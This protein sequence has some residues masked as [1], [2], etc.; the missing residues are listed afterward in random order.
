MAGC[1][2]KIIVFL[3]N[4]IFMLC[5]LAVMIFGIIT[6]ASPSTVI[7]ALSFIPGYQNV[8][9]IIDVQQAVLN[10]GILMT[11]I[12]A[13]TFV[14]C[15]FGLIASCCSVTCLIGTYIF[16]VLI[17][18]YFEVAVII[19]FSVE[20]QYVNNRIENLMYTSLVQNFQPVSIVGN[21]IVNGSTSAAMAWEGIQ[22]KY[23]CCGAY[24]YLDFQN[25]TSWKQNFTYNP[26]A[27]VPPSC[28]Q[29]ITEYQIPTVVSQFSN[30][31]TCLSSAP[32]YTNTKGCFVALQDFFF[33]YGYLKMIIMSGLI[34]VQVFALMFSCQLIHLSQIDSVKDGHY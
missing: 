21:N 8:N 2:A 23:G 27:L 28:C 1:L 14:V 13:V 30:L 31:N 11:V 20:S 10:S 16:M 29:Q 12:G 34:A 7:N 19:Y 22:F 26:A 17:L 32:K 15:I 18:L 24:G 25:F 9:Y 4:F 33:I 3:V 5:G 6:L